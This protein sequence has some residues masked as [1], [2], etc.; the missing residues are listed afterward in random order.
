MTVTKKAS[1]RNLKRGTQI[2][3]V[4][5]HAEGDVNHPDCDRGFVTSV[6]AGMVFCRHWSKKAP[7]PE[8]RTKLCS[9]RRYARDLVVVDSAEQWVVDVALRAWCVPLTGQGVRRP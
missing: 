5:G 8:L 2:I 3:Y 1:L 7:P 4:P 6:R 9:E